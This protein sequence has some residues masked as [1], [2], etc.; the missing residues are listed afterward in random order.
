MKRFKSEKEA[1]DYFDGALAQNV[2]AVSKSFAKVLPK[3]SQVET[4][5]FFAMLEKINWRKP[6][7][8]NIVVLKNKD[9]LKRLDWKDS[10]DLKDF[11]TYLFKTLKHMRTVG[12]IEIKNLKHEDDLINVSG[13]LFYHVEGN[14][15]YTLVLFN[16]KFMPLFENLLKTKNYFTY[17]I[18]DI[19]QLNSKHAQNLYFELIEKSKNFGKGVEKVDFSTKQLKNMFGLSKEAYMST[20][21]FQRTRFEQRT[22][23]KAVEEIQKSKLIKLIP[24]EDGKYYFKKKEN[25]KVDKYIFQYEIKREIFKTVEGSYWYDR[26]SFAEQKKLNEKAREILE[27]RGEIAFYSG[28]ELSK[29]K[30]DLIYLPY[31]NEDIFF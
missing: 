21:G 30:N 23:D 17:W 25:G 13:S 18:A 24:F 9:L 2:V 10:S 7:N 1:I 3:W 28:N 6:D 26:D 11:S 4:K 31:E 8:G 19:Y 29:Y 16:H 14:K 15:D 20:S 12:D 27:E 5:L 22:I